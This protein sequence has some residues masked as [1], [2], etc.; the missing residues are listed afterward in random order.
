MLRPWITVSVVLLAL[1]VAASAQFKDP[2]HGFTFK[3]PKDYVAV[4]LSPSDFFHV[5]KYQDPQKEYGGDQGY[6][7]FNRSF[8]VSYW[9]LGR[10]LTAEDAQGEAPPEGGP[11][12]D[13]EPG[14]DG[15]DGKPGKDAK[16]K[17]DSKPAV[18]K[19]DDEDDENGLGAFSRQLVDYYYGSC[20][21][22]KEK[23]ITIA[24][25]K[26]REMTLKSSRSPLKYYLV[27]LEQPDGRW[28]FEGAALDS[29]FE[30][31]VSEFSKAARSFTRIEKKDQAAHDAELGQMSEQ[32]RFLQRQ[33]DKL[34]PGWDHLRTKRYLF[35]FDAEKSFVQE[36]ATRVEAMR[37]VYEVHYPPTKPITDVSIVRVCK[38]FDEYRGYG[39]SEG[40]G[41]YWN[42]VE[43]ELVLFDYRPRELTLAVLNHEAFHQFI[44]YFYG[45]LAPHSWY[46]EGT[47]DY[48]AGAKL[49]KSNRITGYGD[50]PG[51]I[52]R[53]G[54]IKEAARLLSEGK[55]GAGGACPP[56]KKVMRFHKSDYYGSAGYDPGICYAEGWAIVH[57]LREGKGVD[58]KVAK[59]L[60]DY[61]TSLVAA[62]EEAAKALMV[63]TLADAEVDEKGSS[64]DMSHD[65]KDYYPRIDNEKVQDAAADKTFAGWTDAD[66]D[67]FQ[68]S[69]LKY[70]EKL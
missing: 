48:Y 24:G 23:D 59:I 50:A 31:A 47:G 62:R 49:T 4:A 7:G 25:G 38:N 52:G 61:L 51:G 1:S 15:K 33:I 58:P 28:V 45:Q 70:V 63:K 26:G 43:R 16:P 11:G 36:L 13:E 34:P 37:D 10:S 22:E 57:Y 56:L 30:K 19:S 69:W 20:E 21:V 66:W 9:P 12:G 35:L 3:P 17:K 39:G 53:L 46:N 27:A 65:I 42:W 54:D 6:E 68:A 64:D 44:F 8:E 29:R 32:D 18:D 5:A 14:A 55:N 41:G 40:T 67:K 2:K 60:P